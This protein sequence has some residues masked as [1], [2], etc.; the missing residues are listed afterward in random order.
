MVRHTYGTPE[1][2]EPLGLATST[3]G[4]LGKPSELA[5]YLQVCL[6]K[7]T[8]EAVLGGVYLPDLLQFYLK[9]YRLAAA[10]CE[11]MQVS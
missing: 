4:T 5:C 2:G 10:D 3:I 8:Q 7:S 1:C 11:I 9:S 6:G